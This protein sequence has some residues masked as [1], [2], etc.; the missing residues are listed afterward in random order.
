LQQ[1]A[2]RRALTNRGLVKTTLYL[3]VV[4][5]LFSS[6]I[7]GLLVRGRHA[8]TALAW[9]WEDIATPIT[10]EL[11]HGQKVKYG[12]YDFDQRRPFSRAKGVAIE[13]IFVSWLSP[14]LNDAIGSSFQYASERN[15]WLMITIE[16]FVSEGRNRDQLLDDVIVGAYDPM[17]ASV[18]QSI[19]SLQVPVFVRWGHEMETGDARYPWSGATRESYI[20]AYRHFATRCRPSAPQILLVWSPRGDRTLTEYYPGE[21]YVDFAGLSLYELP[22]YDLD[23]FGKVKSFR[24]SFAPK[25]NRA[26]A[27]NKPIMIA[28]MGVS[29]DPK[30]QARWMADFFRDLQHF[31]WLRTIVY[32]N[33]KDSPGAWPQKYGI[34]DWTIDPNIFE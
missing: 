2:E 10:A 12:V 21:G 32:F 13:H 9:G 31:P 7:A 4:T 8:A 3:L 30:Y 24:D 18:C 26:I 16:P 1:R 15:R 34:P 25:Y 11:K 20:A 33:A 6:A 5:L 27:Y 29:G 28:E 22:A 23:H 17:I 14:D 19:G